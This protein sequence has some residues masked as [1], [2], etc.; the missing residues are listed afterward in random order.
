MPRM[1]R[2]GGRLFIGWSSLRCLQTR[3]VEKHKSTSFSGLTAGGI[4]CIN[5]SKTRSAYSTYGFRKTTMSKQSVTA[6]A[7]ADLS[8]ETYNTIDHWSGKGLLQFERKGRTRLYEP[9]QNMRIIK[10]I[11]DLQNKGHSL[12]GIRD[13]LSNAQ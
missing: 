10:Q 12:E 6:K 4:R 11:R 9:T 1:G 13:N 2:D 7:L 3:S 5:T 8:N